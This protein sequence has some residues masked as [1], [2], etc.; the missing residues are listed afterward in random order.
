M[1]H[2]LAQ[3]DR[4]LR[5]EQVQILDL[6]LPTLCRILP[7]SLHSLRHLDPDPGRYQGPSRPTETA[8]LDCLDLARHSRCLPLLE[9]HNLDHSPRI[10]DRLVA[11]TQFQAGRNLVLSHSGCHSH[12]SKARSKGSHPDYCLMSW[13]RLNH[14]SLWELIPTA[15]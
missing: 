3:Q 7:D 11:Q 1:S 13:D 5:K 9:A 6:G 8:V 2:F 10:P 15:G 14:L 4:R 12:S